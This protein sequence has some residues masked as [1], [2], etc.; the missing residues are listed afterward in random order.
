MRK[1]KIDKLNDKFEHDIDAYVDKIN[2]VNLNSLHVGDIVKEEVTKMNN[3][4]TR[5]SP[6]RTGAYAKSWEQEEDKR[7]SSTYFGMSVYNTTTS[8]K[9]GGKYPANLMWLLENGHITK[10]HGV[11]GWAE[12]HP[13]IVKNYTNAKKAIIARISQSLSDQLKKGGHNGK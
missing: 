11:V 1:T 5:D 12:P 4:I 2:G 8:K 3:N 9:T 6:D 13:H 7:N 10:S